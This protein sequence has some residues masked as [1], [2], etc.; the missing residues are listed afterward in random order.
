MKQIE[1]QTVS[2]WHWR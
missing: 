2:L 1:V